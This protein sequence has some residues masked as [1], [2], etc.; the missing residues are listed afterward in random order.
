[1]RVALCVLV[2]FGV[3]A[4]LARFGIHSSTKATS[5]TWPLELCTAEPPYRDFDTYYTPGLFYLDAAVFG[6]FGLIFLR[7]LQSPKYT[8]STYGKSETLKRPRNR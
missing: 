5:W 4:W 6:V 2:V 1:M 3:Y 7:D 8:S